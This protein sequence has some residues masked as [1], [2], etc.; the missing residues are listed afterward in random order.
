MVWVKIGEGV[1]GAEMEAAIGDWVIGDQHIK[2]FVETEETNLR[3]LMCI[4]DK[5]F[6]TY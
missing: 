5:K 1:V 6:R 3:K 2:R 4:N